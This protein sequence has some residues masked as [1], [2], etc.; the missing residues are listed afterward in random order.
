MT[1]S[2]WLT[3][4][5]RLAALGAALALPARAMA[6][7]A[8]FSIPGG[9][10]MVGDGGATVAPGGVFL[11]ATGTP[12]ASFTFVVP[13]DYVRNSTI[14]LVLYLHAVPESC[15]FVLVPTTVVHRRPGEPV[16]GETSVLAPKDGSNVVAAPASNSV[17]FTKTYA[18][19]P[20]GPLKGIRKGDQFLIALS[21]NND[22]PDDGCNGLVVVEA[23][24]VRYSTP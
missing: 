2:R 13:R 12:S 4:L 16:D 19:T 1:A 7:S 3:A 22:D 21:R 20:G 6:G 23:V 24:D 8:S 15:T 18:L 17:P 10:A 9:G 11:P 14:S 5:L